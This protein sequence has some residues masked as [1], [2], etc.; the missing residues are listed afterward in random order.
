MRE[1]FHSKIPRYHAMQKPLGG[2]ILDEN[3]SISCL[4]GYTAYWCISWLVQETFHMA[5][6]YHFI[7]F[8]LFL[9]CHSII[10]SHAMRRSC[11]HMH[12]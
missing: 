12:I 3:L 11:S 10:T 5:N 6:S 7:E 8:I 4:F 1:H 9:N 2:D